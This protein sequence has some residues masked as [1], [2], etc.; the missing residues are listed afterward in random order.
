MIGRSYVV[1]L[2]NKGMTTGWKVFL[3]SRSAV[4]TF[5]RQIHERYPHVEE[6]HAWEMTP[7]HYRGYYAPES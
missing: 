7:V 4:D 5:L 2:R 3:S 1:E 6:A